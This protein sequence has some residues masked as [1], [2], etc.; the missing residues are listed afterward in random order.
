MRNLSI[1]DLEHVDRREVDFSSSS[2]DVVRIH[3]GGVRIKKR[4]GFVHR[5]PEEEY[6]VSLSYSV[7]PRSLVLASDAPLLFVSCKEMSGKSITI[8]VDSNEVEVDVFLD[9]KQIKDCENRDL[10]TIPLDYTIRITNSSGDTKEVTKHLELTPKQMPLTRPLFEFIPN[11]AGLGLTYD[12][13]QTKKLQ[14]GELHIRHSGHSLYWP[15]YQIS[16]SI[17]AQ[18]I[19]RDGK[20]IPV[21]D[22]VSLDVPVDKN[23]P[24]NRVV[25]S[26]PRINDTICGVIP[27]NRDG[28]DFDFDRLG[29]NSVRL[30]N[31]EVNMVA[32]ARENENYIS[33]PLL[34]DMT[35]TDN[36]AE[37]I[38][39]FTLYITA[40]YGVNELDQVNTFYDD[41]TIDLHRN[42][43]SMNLDVYLSDGEERLMLCNGISVPERKPELFGYTKYCL[44]LHNS[45][46]AG[47]ESARIY[48]KNFECIFP[49]ADGNYV[50]RK[51]LNQDDLFVLLDNS[52]TFELG[53]AKTKKIGFDFDYSCVES[54]VGVG[55]GVHRKT[56]D[57]QIRFDYFIDREGIFPNGKGIPKY[58][59]FESTIPIIVREE[60]RP[61]WLCV[62]F[63]TSAVV[64]TF[65]EH[66]YETP[67]EP[68]FPPIDLAEEKKRRLRKWYKNDENLTNDTSEVSPFITSTAV[69]N[70]LTTTINETGLKASLDNDSADN[71]YPKCPVMFSPSNKVVDFY[72]WM[73]PS[74]KS[75][76]GIKYLPADLLPTNVTANGSIRVDILFQLIYKQFF[77]LFLPQN[78]R[79]ATNKLVMTVPNTYAP[80]HIDEIRALAAKFIPNLWPDYTRFMSESDAVAFY[81]L[82]NKPEI[83]ERSGSSIKDLDFDRRV[84]VYDMGAGTLDL[85]YFTRHEEG[86]KTIIDIKGKMGVSKAGNYLDYLLAEILVDKICAR[87]SDEG[88]KNKIK[89]LLLLEKSPLR[90]PAEA[91][92]LKKYVRDDLKPILNHD[93]S[94]HLPKLRLYNVD[95]PTNDITIIE[96]LED[97]RMKSDQTG[98]LKS[99]SS[100]IFKHFKALFDDVKANDPVQPDLVIFSGRTT[101]LKC[102][103]RSVMDALKVF[104]I[105][106]CH[107]LDLSKGIIKSEVNDSADDE[108]DIRSL[109]TA[110]VDGA[111]S[112]CSD[113]LGGQGDYVLKNRN[114]Y[115]QYGIMFRRGSD[116]IWEKLIDIHTRPTNLDEPKLSDDGMTIYT[117]DTDKASALDSD[118]FG[119]FEGSILRKRDFTSFNEAFLLQSYSSDTEKDWRDGNRELISVISRYDLSRI[120]G[121]KHYN[122][123]INE[124]NQIKFIIGTGEMNHDPCG[125]VQSKSFRK[126]IWPIVH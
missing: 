4:G 23:A 87:V 21:A 17:V 24:G 101:N 5:H 71:D 90:V 14:I 32:G 120:N 126:S 56:L 73:L 94:E 13:S 3:R 103:R 16:F 62:D 92:K 43:L 119:F 108:N 33:I 68:T 47:K 67:G 63:G 91:S 124:E 28:S 70:N 50:P 80:S 40:R 41:L 55:H 109:K 113:F 89:S 11:E 10:K 18:M 39:K 85:T 115:A 27:E 114:I 96:I 46:R 15:A 31:V 99:V 122:L 86:V 116:W 110:V 107:Y 82:A 45:A 44:E 95:L 53:I 74:L 98:F 106:Q 78:N 12:K 64:A 117:Y 26:M 6:T 38:Q 81:Y 61:E 59:Q 75:L 100:D 37:D 22:L 34:W 118:G 125:D 9:R 104:G 35:K 76:M 29:N 105:D 48:V 57:V 66:L 1:V 60:P 72:L 84:L 97:D 65:R 102:I 121:D 77:E 51:G 93:L 7:P 2:K 20:R 19:N 79:K 30:K 54:L 112:F 36:P 42:L 88:L 52:N 111:L 58:D 8:S 83:L 49:K 69:I 123:V 25:Q